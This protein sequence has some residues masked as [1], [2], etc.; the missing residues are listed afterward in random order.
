MDFGGSL[1]F[2]AMQFCKRKS[3]VRD[4]EDERFATGD[5]EGIR[6]AV[7]Y[8][9]FQWRYLCGRYQVA[10]AYMEDSNARITVFAPVNGGWKYLLN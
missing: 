8:S 6:I 2:N 5:K 4:C 3:V 1:P 7:K 10:Q 9:T